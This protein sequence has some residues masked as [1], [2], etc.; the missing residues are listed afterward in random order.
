MGGIVLVILAIVA[1]IIAGG[2]RGGRLDGLTQ[3]EPRLLPALLVGLALEGAAALATALG[4]VSGAVP[5]VTLLGLAALLLFAA[6]NHRL[7]GMLLIGL[8][9]LC[10]LAVIGL[11]GG[12]P[13]TEGARERAGQ[14]VTN[15]PPERPDA[16][17]VRVD[18]GTRLRLLGDVLAV[19]PFRTVVSVGD[20][21][22]Y[23]GVF[24]LVQGLVVHG[25][26]AKRPQYE[27]FD[28]RAG[29]S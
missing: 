10:N 21:A 14:V 23:A 29:S 8:G 27:F 9:V 1:G 19:R 15:P 3:A 25:E 24:L 17:H 26:L 16:R 20:I 12:M 6:A 22:Q 2:L 11:N 28:Y 4:W 7:P 13:V 5:A 18:S